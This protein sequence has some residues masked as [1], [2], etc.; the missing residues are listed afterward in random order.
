MNWEDRWESRSASR[1]MNR[2]RDVEALINS[3]LRHRAHG[4]LP[5]VSRADDGTERKLAEATLANISDKLIEAQEQERAR[6]AREL[7]DDFGQRLAI[8]G[9]GVAQLWKALPESEIENRARARKLLDE[10]RELSADLHS[11]SHQLHSSKLEHVGIVSALVGLCREI[12]SK[13][14]IEVQFKESRLAP[15]IPKDVALCLFRV[16][17]EALRNVVKHSQA[18]RAH[19]ELRANASSVTLFV[20]DDG[21]GFDI[22]GNKPSSGIGLIGMQERVRQV[23]GMFLVKSRPMLGT[24]IFTEVPLPTPAHKG[25]A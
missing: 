22:D 18:K 16:A 15:D 8:I 23:A 19:V 20:T 4:L 6:I 12:T 7:H 1:H 3:S 9:I 24:E 25:R 14:G 17:Q 11:L 13:Y 21:Q 10:I 2:A 5:R